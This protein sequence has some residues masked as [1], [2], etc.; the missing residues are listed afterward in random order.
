MSATRIFDNSLFAVDIALDGNI[1][2]SFG[3]EY[4]FEEDELIELVN[5]LVKMGVLGVRLTGRS[6]SFEKCVTPGEIP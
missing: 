5:F 6:D 2:Y 3:D 1:E 4:S